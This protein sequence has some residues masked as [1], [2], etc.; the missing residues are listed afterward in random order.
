LKV[1]KGDHSLPKKRTSRKKRHDKP[2]KLDS[3]GGIIINN[4]LKDLELSNLEGEVSNMVGERL[5]T[6]RVVRNFEDVESTREEGEFAH[7]LNAVIC[8]ES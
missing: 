4:K 6:G 7:M 1:E 3:F 2:G 5:C 8:R